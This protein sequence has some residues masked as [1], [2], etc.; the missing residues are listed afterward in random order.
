VGGLCIPLTLNKC[1]PDTSTRASS[2]SPSP[3]YTL[4]V[5]GNRIYIV[6]SPSLVASV[7][8]NSKAI[9]FDPYVVQ[10][11]KRIAAPSPEGLAAIAANL[12]EDAR[13]VSSAL[14]P[15]EHLDRTTDAVLE[16]VCNLLLWDHGIAEEVKGG[17]FDLFLWIRRLVTK[18][19]TDGIYGVRENPF[20]DPKVENGFW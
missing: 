16:S 5:P 6:N 1:T 14:A 8:R 9:S 17:T 11:A 4:L 13:C 2:L 19:S 12:D 10:F 3:I 15:G 7:D 18:A 20:M